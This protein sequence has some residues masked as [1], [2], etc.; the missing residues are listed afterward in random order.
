MDATLMTILQC[1]CVAFV[2]MLY[3]A[4]GHGG[5]TGYIALLSLFGLQHEEIATTALILNTAVA[6]ISLT[7]YYRAGRFNI[8]Q[9][10]PYLIL[11]IPLAYLGARLPV[12]KQ[13]FAYILGTM[14]AL[15]ALRFAA[16]PGKNVKDQSKNNNSTSHDL[17]APEASADDE[18]I[19]PPSI[20]LAA[21]AGGILGLLSGIVGIGGGVFLSP[22]II[23]K[24]WATTKQTAAISALFIV[25]NSISGLAGRFS[26][27]R[28]EMIHLLPFLLVAAPAAIIGSTYGASKFTSR[29][30]QRLLAIV[31]ALAAI[32]LFQTT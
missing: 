22:L 19:Q 21:G 8:K 29:N 6:S 30:L 13:T 23:F 4:V 14:L 3:A 32:K 16:L 2:A 7:N 27:G 25:V 11:S 17:S 28:G 18:K 5:A 12:D 15:A 1:L 24:H 31:L 9:A 26:E 20:I 10:L